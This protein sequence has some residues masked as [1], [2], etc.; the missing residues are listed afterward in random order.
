[1]IIPL[2]DDNP[3]TRLPVFMVSILLLNIGVFL[4]AY[5]LGETG[6]RVFTD[7]YGL[8]PLEVTQL[9]DAIS[10][11]PI[12]FLLTLFTAMFM[13]GG[14]AHLGGNMLYLWIFG[15]NVEDTLGHLR[16]LGFYLF[17]GLVATLAHVISAPDSTLPLVGASGAIAGVLGAY[18]AAFPG[19]RVHVLFFYLV[20]RIPALLVLGIW[21]LIQ[22]SNAS[23][24]PEV[25]GGVAWYAHIAGFVVG[26]LIMRRRR[27]RIR[28]VDVSDSWYET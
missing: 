28:E 20:L 12:P 17:C 11:T 25:E 14:W 16:F 19:A 10:P 6:F 24:D 2:K 21:F 7:K 27:E 3:T 4:Y 18:M 13:H 8:I 9:T 1:M 23:M 22:L 5:F 15:N 26:Y